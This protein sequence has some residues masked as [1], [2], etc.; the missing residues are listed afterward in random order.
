MCRFIDHMQEKLSVIEQENKLV[1]VM[2]GFNINLLNYENYSPTNDFINM[3]SA[4]YFQPCVLHPICVT[5]AT[6]AVIDNIF[7]NNAMSSNIQRG[8]VLLQISDYSPQ[9]CK[10]NNCIF[11]Y[12]NFFHFSYD[13]SHFNTDKLL[14]GYA[15]IGIPWS[16]AQ[17]TDLN[18]NF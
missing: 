6:S 17:T 15:E 18:V 5:D 12:K 9:F 8:H 11:N 4:H 1:F 2:G 10:I 7:V 14:A 16:T 13:Y 3:I